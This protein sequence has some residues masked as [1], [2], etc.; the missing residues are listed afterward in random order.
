MQKKT[1]FGKCRNLP[2]TIG[3]HGGT[4]Y[5]LTAETAVRILE[6]LRLQEF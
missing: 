5:K 3:K 4:I 2:L 1:F 6:K